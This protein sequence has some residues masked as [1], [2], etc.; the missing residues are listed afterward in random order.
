MHYAVALLSDKFELGSPNPT[1]PW[2]RLRWPMGLSG[3][4]KG[5]SLLSGCWSTPGCEKGLSG[6]AR[7]FKEHKS[8]GLAA[9]VLFKLREEFVD[10]G[11]TSAD[12]L[13]R[14]LTVTNE[15]RN[16]VPCLG[17][18]FLPLGLSALEGSRAD[19]PR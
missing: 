3:A 1:L 8:R 15:L 13:I 14:R 12:E 7:A 9:I 19:C 10:V 2:G 4:A 17:L 6:L 18:Q 16:I 11:Q 5:R